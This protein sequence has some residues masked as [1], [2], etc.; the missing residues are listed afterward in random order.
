M[1][2][3]QKFIVYKHNAANHNMKMTPPELKTI[4]AFLKNENIKLLARDRDGRINSS[5]NETQVLSALSLRN[6]KSKFPD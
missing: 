2:V 3:R 4:V 6:S 1:E 5:F